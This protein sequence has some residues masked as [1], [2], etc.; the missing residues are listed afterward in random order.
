MCCQ[1]YVYLCIT[2]KLPRS[3]G[4]LYSASSSL[5]LHFRCIKNSILPQYYEIIQD[6]KSLGVNDFIAFT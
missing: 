3:F 5:T 1:K 6:A 4:R 2:K